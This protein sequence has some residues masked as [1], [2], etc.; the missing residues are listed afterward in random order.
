MSEGTNSNPLKD[1][2]DADQD[3]GFART[4]EVLVAHAP[5]RAPAQDDRVKGFTAPGS[6]PCPAMDDWF[7]LAGGEIDADKR[8]ALLGHAALCSS[9][10]RRLRESKELLSENVTPDEAAELKQFAS[11]SPEWQRRLA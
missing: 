10:L 6:G 9:C 11:T 1:A 3:Q 8:T 2:A 5:F 4:L 7:R